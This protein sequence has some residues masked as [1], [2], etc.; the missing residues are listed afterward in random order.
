MSAPYDIEK[1]EHL[2]G[3]RL[4]LTF[5]D[6]LMSEVD[7]AGKLEGQVGPIFEPLKDPDFFSR[8]TV[9]EELHTVVWPNGADLASDALHSALRSAT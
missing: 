4:R 3:Y 2:G 9:D 5:A 8:A 7:L 6:G 1:V